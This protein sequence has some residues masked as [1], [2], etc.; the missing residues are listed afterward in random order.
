MSECK[1]HDVDFREADCTQANFTFTDFYHS[2]FNKTILK[3]ADFSDSSNYSINVFFNDIK[4]A[5]FTLPEAVNL[6]QSLE[7]ELGD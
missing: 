2:L 1:A 6:L 3:E 7:I 4:K 5:K